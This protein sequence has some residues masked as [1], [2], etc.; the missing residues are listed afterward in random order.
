MIKIKRQKRLVYNN[1]EERAR[2]IALRFGDFLDGK[3]LDA[4]CWRKDLKKY[5]SNNTDYVGVD[6]NGVPDIRI[7][8]EKEK[9]PFVNNYFDCVVCSDVLEHLDNFHEVFG[10][11]IRVSKNYTI[12]SFPNNWLCLKNILLKSGGDN[13]LKFYGLPIEKPDDR[14][15]WFFNYQEAENFI[16]TGT[17]KFHYEVIINEPYFVPATFVKSFLK[18]I[19]RILLGKERYNNLF[20]SALWVVLKKN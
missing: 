17:K 8:L 12:L 10:E 1:R 15:K 4:G 2:F 9:L 3:V 11:L 19:L 18:F 13:K 16:L 5:L 6:I 20:A 14:H 7:D